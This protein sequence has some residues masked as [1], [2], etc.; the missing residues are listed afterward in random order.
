MNINTRA[1]TA[2]KA[3]EVIHSVKYTKHSIGMLTVYICDGDFA[4]VMCGSTGEA[5]LIQ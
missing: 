4:I 5:M 2:E 3:A 1:L